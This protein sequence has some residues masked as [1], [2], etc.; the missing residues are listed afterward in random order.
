LIFGFSYR[1]NPLLAINLNN[2]TMTALRALAR[3][4]FM[5]VTDDKTPVD[6]FDRR[7]DKTPLNEASKLLSGILFVNFENDEAWLFLNPRAKHKLTR[8]HLDRIF[9]FMLLHIVYFDDFSH[10]DY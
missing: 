5:Q 3:R 8:D 1:L 4:A 6:K 7:A 9:D 2:S 10:D